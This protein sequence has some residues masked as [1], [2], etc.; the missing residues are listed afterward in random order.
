MKKI[1]AVVGI[2]YQDGKVFVTRRKEGQSFTGLCEFAGGKI[3]KG[4][5]PFGAMVREVQ[6]EIG[7]NVEKAVL[8]E[9]YKHQYDDKEVE[10]YFYLATQYKGKPFGKEGQDGQWIAISDLKSEEFLSGTKVIIDSLQA[11]KYNSFFT[12]SNYSN[13]NLIWIDLEMTG[14]EPKSDRILEI[15]T[16]VTDKDLNVLAKGPV[17]AVK[18]SDDMLDTMNDWC[19]N[20]HYT[21]GL[22]KRVQESHFNEQS[23][24][25]ETIAFLEYFIKQGCSPICGNSVAQDKRFLYEYMPKLANFFHYRM[26]DVSTIKE[27]ARRWEEDIFENVPRKKSV[28]LALDDII[29]SIEELQYYRKELFK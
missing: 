25:A 27:L 9:H 13:D 11:G 7:V 3:E 19:K 18:Q 8:I 2:V 14:L 6:E 17:I 22:I 28:H 23:A 15:A 29:E 4:E 21:S 1:V 20:T 5:S 24:E 26:I 16:I 12:K 10:L